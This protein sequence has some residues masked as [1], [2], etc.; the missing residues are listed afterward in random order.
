MKNYH[1]SRKLQIT[2]P[3]VLARDLDIGPGDS[4]VFEK[5]GG[6]MLVKKAGAHVW[7]RRELEQTVNAL[8]RDMTRIRKH[9]KAAERFFAE[10]LSG[11][12]RSSATKR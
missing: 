3:K 6:A 5:V 1:V 7:R 9:A 11:N 12:G 10:N 2:I 4:V 8:A